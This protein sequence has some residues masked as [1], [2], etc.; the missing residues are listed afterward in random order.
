MAKQVSQKKKNRAAQQRRTNLTVIIIIAAFAVVVVGMIIL[1]Q[2][3]NTPSA[4]SV[5]IPT[6]T[7]KPQE[8][9]LNLGDPNAKVKVIEFADFQCIVCDQYWQQLE[10]A[11]ISTYVA[12]GEVYYTFSPFVIFTQNSESQDAAEAA[13][14]ANDQGKFWEYHDTLFTNY[15]GEYKGSYTP[16]RLKAMAEGLG[17]DMNAFNTCYDNQKYAT[18]IQSDDAYARSNNVQGTPSF[19]VNGKLVSAAELQTT[20]DA[21]LAATK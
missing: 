14:C 20:I 13:Y 21:A 17:L 15:L 1:T 4:A 8:S 16:A 3:K 10:P 2:L 6:L 11:I 5:T 9:G 12:T 19:L 18:Q 7:A